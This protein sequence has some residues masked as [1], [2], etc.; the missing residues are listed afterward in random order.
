[1]LRVKLEFEQYARADDEIAETRSR[2]GGEVTAFGIQFD[3]EIP[4]GCDA[5]ATGSA[6]DKIIG[7]GAVTAQCLKAEIALQIR[8]E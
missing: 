5:D 3:G 6:I 7:G 4:D 2:A 8:A 1:M